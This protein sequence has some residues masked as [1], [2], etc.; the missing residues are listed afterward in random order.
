[1]GLFAESWVRGTGEE[2]GLEDSEVVENII[3]GDILFAIAQH[4]FVYAHINQ[5]GS[6]AEILFIADELEEFSRYGRQ[7][8]SREYSDTTAEAAIEFTPQNPKQ[9]EDVEINIV[10]DYD[11]SRGLDDYFDFFRRK[12]ER[13][14]TVYSLDL[15]KGSDKYCTIN[16]I[17]IT[18]KREQ[19]GFFFEL[20]K[21]TENKNKG[22]L[23]KTKIGTEDYEEGEYK[24]SC[25]DDR[26]DVL[27]KNDKVDLK[28]WCRDAHKQ[29]P[30]S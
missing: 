17:K 19:Y 11:T 7:L 25:T 22:Y 4:E 15:E 20:R 14:C 23:P 5:V 2:W 10:Y 30:S 6:L 12:A 1:M 26:I 28:D 3:R 13:L 8:L 27:T 16:R 29:Y 24:L 21:G 18:A 9:G